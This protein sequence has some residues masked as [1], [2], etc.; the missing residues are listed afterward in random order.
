MDIEG[1]RILGIDEVGRGCIAG[2][3]Y[4][5]ACL[6][7]TQPPFYVLDMIKDSKKLSRNQRHEAFKA[8]AKYASWNYQSIEAEVI[9]EKGLSECLIW[10][11]KR[12]LQSFEGKYD[13][14]IYN[15]KW[16]PIK[17]PNFMTMI[18]ADDKIKEVSAASIIAKYFRD[19]LM[20]EHYDPLYPEYGFKNHVGYGTKA[21][22]EAI[23]KY[24]Y[25]PIHRKTFKIKELE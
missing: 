5:A 6:F 8:F 11:I 15:G 22:T 13:I 16:D 21:H 14:A 23:R 19:N 4:V 7:N 20:I 25:T 3:M 24:G 10:S 12:L 18:K 2:P 17:Q 1:K 9:D